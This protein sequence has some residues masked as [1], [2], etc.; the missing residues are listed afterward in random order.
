MGAGIAPASDA[1]PRRMYT[2]YSTT[3]DSDDVGRE[4][5]YP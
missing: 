4:K 2:L 1:T 3:I 5:R